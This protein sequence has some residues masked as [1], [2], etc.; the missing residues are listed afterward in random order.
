LVFLKRSLIVLAL[1]GGALVRVFNTTGM[2][3][4]SCGVFSRI[5]HPQQAGIFYFFVFKGENC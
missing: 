2:V 5:T 3:L 1:A 4:L